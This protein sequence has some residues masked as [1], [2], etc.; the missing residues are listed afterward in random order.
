MV[1][2]RCYGLDLKSYKIGSFTGKEAI[3]ERQVMRITSHNLTRDYSEV[4]GDK[5]FYA[6]FDDLNMVALTEPN[7]KYQLVCIEIQPDTIILWHKCPDGKKKGIY[8]P[9]NY[10]LRLV[11]E[12]DYLDGGRADRYRIRGKWDDDEVLITD[13]KMKLRGTKRHMVIY[14]DG[15]GYV[16]ERIR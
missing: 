10:G 11:F 4:V 2:N 5:D 15:A 3:D 9:L 13:I 6:A 7:E 8:C 14:E 1:K 16:T 12:V